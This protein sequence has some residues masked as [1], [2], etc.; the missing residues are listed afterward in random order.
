MKKSIL[1]LILLLSASSLSAQNAK[2]GF[3]L[4]GRFGNENLQV[5]PGCGIDLL[6]FMKNNFMFECSYNRMFSKRIYKNDYSIEKYDYSQKSFYGTLIYVFGTAKF[7]PYIGL[8]I[9]YYKIDYDNNRVSHWIKD[10][11]Y[12]LEYEKI[13]SKIGYHI[14]SGIF[15]PAFR[16]ITFNIMLQYTIL[17]PSVIR[18]FMS[19]YS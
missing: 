15:I 11:I 7:R 1:I 12:Y 2:I 8:G 9:G 17:R 19:G 5:N 13:K 6:F 16:N 4:S 3:H 18:G 14:S 10:T